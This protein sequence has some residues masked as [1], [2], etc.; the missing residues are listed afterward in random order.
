LTVG[1]PYLLLSATS[2]LIQVWFARV[3]PKRD[4][5]RL[6]ALSN[7]GSLI[8]LG[9]FP[10]V[11]EPN[12]TRVQTVYLWSILFAFFAVLCAVVVLLARKLYYWLESIIKWFSYRN[13]LKQ[14][15]MQ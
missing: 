11:F 3:F 5:Y 12:F 1:L 8:A 7:A 14:K 13:R 10:F 4:P 6:Y 9:S 15:K 2:P